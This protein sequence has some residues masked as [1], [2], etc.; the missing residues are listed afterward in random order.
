[1]VEKIENPLPTRSRE[2]LANE[3]TFLAWIRTCIGIMAFGFVIEKFAVFI[4]KIASLFEKQ[5]L[6][7][8]TNISTVPQEY[9]SFFGIFLIIVGVLIGLFAFIK[10]HRNEK[11]IEDDTYQ[12]SQTLS[13]VTTILLFVIG[14]FLIVFLINT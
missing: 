6:P 4:K 5:T 10:Y 12:P 1:M 3:R 7:E 8:K 9:P 14:I 11:Q 13:I 2:H